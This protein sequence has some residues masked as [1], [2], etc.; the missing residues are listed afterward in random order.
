M[1]IKKEKNGFKYTKNGWHYVSIWGKPYERGYAHGKLLAKEIKD[2]L[3]CMKWVLED[4]H[5]FD[6]D[7]FLY[8]ED[9]DIF[10][11]VQQHGYRNYCWRTT[12]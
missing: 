10:Y 2:A 7:F 1:D 8:G 6:E 4:S 9:L 5:G 11:R 3:K 12:A